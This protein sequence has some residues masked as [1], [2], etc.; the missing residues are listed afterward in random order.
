MINLRHEQIVKRELTQMDF[1]IKC[2]TT[3]LV[4][5][6]THVSVTIK[7]ISKQSLTNYKNTLDK[8]ITGLKKLTTLRHKSIVSLLDCKESNRNIYLVSEV[9]G[10]RHLI[11]PS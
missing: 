9:S 8:E 7:C 2:I 6:Q 11:N 10:H 3:Y 5:L 4:Y 1:T